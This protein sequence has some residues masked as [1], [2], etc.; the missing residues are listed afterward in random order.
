MTNAITAALPNTFVQRGERGRATQVNPLVA[1]KVMSDSEVRG[2]D[3]G[4]T[5]N[6][7]RHAT[8]KYVS[9]PTEAAA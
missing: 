8:T 1:K 5:P 7:P 3:R 6:Q 9:T 2:L 4:A